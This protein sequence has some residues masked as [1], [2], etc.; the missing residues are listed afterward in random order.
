MSSFHFFLHSTPSLSN[1]TLHSSLC[2]TP[3][4]LTNTPLYQLPLPLD[5]EDTATPIPGDY[6]QYYTENYQEGSGIFL[7]SSDI[8]LLHSEY[9][10]T[11][12][13]LDLV[14][15]VQEAAIPYKCGQIHVFEESDSEGVV[16]VTHDTLAC[17]DENNDN[18]LV[19]SL[20]V[21]EYGL[22]MTKPYIIC[23]S[24]VQ[25]QSVIPGCSGSLYVTNHAQMNIQS[26]EE[27]SSITSLHANV[28]IDHSIRIFLHTRVPSTMVNACKVHVS[29]G[30]PVS[31][32]TV[33]SLTSFN[34]SVN[35]YVL[36]DIPAHNYYNICAVLQVE[37][38]PLDKEQVL[39]LLSHNGQCMIASTPSI[40]Y[41]TRSVQPLLLTLI[42]LSIGIAC[43]TVLYFIIKWCIQDNKQPPHMQN[44]SSI[45]PFLVFCWRVRNKASRQHDCLSEDV[46]DDDL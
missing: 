37:E 33:L 22:S 32:P 9:N 2:S 10:H 20:N 23:I 34:C 30:L 44:Q 16:L 42:F 21:E 5:C 12:H 14:W 45:S 27:Q 19:T 25:N 1:S 3:T 38:S 8:H 17:D 11:S 28:S 15:R 46:E 43:L 7:S 13:I 18:T 39:D 24:L 41:H 35:E 29:V 6:Y 36:A 40:R 26:L 4:Y 31:P